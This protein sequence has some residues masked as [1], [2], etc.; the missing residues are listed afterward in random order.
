M[1]SENI[2]PDVVSTGTLPRRE[3]VEQLMQEA[4]DRYALV[5]EGAVADY[6]P[7]LAQ[8]DPNLFGLSIVS[9]AGASHSVGDALHEFSIQSVSKAFVFA[10]VCDA[11]GPEAVLEAVGVNN[12]GLPFNS[13]MALELNGGSPMNPLV[14]AGALTTTSLAPGES[15]DDK[16]SFVQAGLSAFAGRPLVLDEDVYASEAAHNRRNQAIARLL[17]SYGRIVHDPLEVT[18]VYTRQCSLRVSAQDLAVMGA[19]LADGGVNPV[20]GERVVDPSV[21][22]YVLAALATSG[23]YERS[24]E[25]LFSIGLPGKSGVSGGIVTVVPGKGSL[26]TFSPRLDAAGNS[27]RGQLATRYLSGALGLNLFASRP[28]PGAGSR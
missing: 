15:A 20:T 25:W 22:R 4:H 3:L 14:N 5:E 28:E 17:E 24:G 12:T 16:W 26:A 2:D 27:V 10:L 9:V 7:V 1:T 18:D 13:V 6:I 23:L 8:A 19:T 21:C 11:L